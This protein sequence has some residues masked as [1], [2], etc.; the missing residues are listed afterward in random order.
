MYI[1]LNEQNQYLRT[2]PSGNIEFSPTVFQPAHTLTPEQAEQ[3]RVYPLTPAEAPAYNPITHAVRP[4]DPALIDGQW[5]QQWDVFQLSDAE[6]AERTEALKTSLLNQV[7]QL[8]W[9][10]ETGGI[11]LPGG[12]RVGTSIEDQNRIT[13]VTANAKLAGVSTVDFKAAT[14]WVT[15]TLAEVQGI[16]AAI[17][18][19]VQAC[20][21]AERAHH[22][23]IDSI[24]TLEGLRG[25]DLSAGW[26]G[27][28]E[29]AP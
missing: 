21:S 22:E 17:A 10:R 8:R 14:G 4:A 11:T 20:F 24:T 3:F 13:S 28:S 12:V 27:E 26:P 7:T 29:G 5:V 23:A 9:E 2:L 16:A 1:Q 15:L 25:H 18:T 19:H 6:I